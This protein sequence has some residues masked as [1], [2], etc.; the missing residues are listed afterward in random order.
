VAN[1]INL[2]SLEGASK[3]GKASWEGTG[4]R[5]SRD[6]F[7]WTMDDFSF[8]RRKD[9]QTRFNVRKL[10]YLEHL[11]PKELP[12]CSRDGSIDPSPPP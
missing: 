12:V 2:P 11:T 5:G 9:E 7:S 4:G 6:V 8:D 1:K 3:C 10:T